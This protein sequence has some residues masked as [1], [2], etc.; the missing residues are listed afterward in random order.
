VDVG[1]R[2]CLEMFR[3]NGVVVI[4]P[5]RVYAQYGT[6]FAASGMIRTKILTLSYGSTM[7]RYRL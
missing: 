7:D 5:R 3:T 6:P 1:E 4:N 2:T